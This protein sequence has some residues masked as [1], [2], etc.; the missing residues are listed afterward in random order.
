LVVNG[1][2]M[3]QKLEFRRLGA[4]GA[5]AGSYLAEN[6]LLT[7]AIY[8]NPPEFFEDSVGTPQLNG[9]GERQPLY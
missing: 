9:Q 2:V 8:L 1:F 6:V 4:L 5:P 3:G 7:A